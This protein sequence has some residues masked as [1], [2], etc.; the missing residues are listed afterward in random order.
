M[1][2]ERHR[3]T[4][5][6]VKLRANSQCFLFVLAWAFGW[7]ALAGQ[8]EPEPV[9]GE[10]ARALQAGNYRVA[11]QLVTAALRRDQ[12]NADLWNLLGIA[13]SELQ[14]LGA[15]EEAFGK[16]LKLAPE[17]ISLNENAGLLFFRE[18]KYKQAKIALG[19]AVQLGSIKPEVGFSL[20]AAKL[21]SGEESAALAELRALQPALGTRAEYWEERGRAE[22]LA[23]PAGAEKSFNHAIELRPESLT[24]LNGAA[25]AAEKQKLDEKALA[26]LIKARE[27]S[28]GDVPTLLHFASICIRRDLG[29]DAIIALEQARRFEPANQAAIYLLA[30]ANISVQNWQTAYDLFRIFSRSHPDY[31]PAYYAMGWIDIRLNRVDDAR[32]ELLHCLRLEPGMTDARYDLAQLEYDDGQVEAAGKLLAAVLRD[33]PNHAKANMTMGDIA[34]HRGD[35]A[36]AQKYLEAAVVSD[37]RL[38]AAHYKLSA[39]YLRS[40]H[41]DKAEQEKKAA[42]ALTAEANRASKTQLRLILP[43]VR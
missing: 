41:P 18:A 6:P 25:A 30:R 34:L 8:Q 1:G 10:A 4:F 9:M 23:E 13:R 11:E 5:L 39:V 31:A 40:N 7:P 36:S 15:A 3:K 35:L 19:K 16:G 2:S 26:Y 12:R 24:A 27:V 17:S 28:P 37:P 22:L 14:E 33:Q 42:A 21:R 20:A 29:P 43:D 32:Q 38:A